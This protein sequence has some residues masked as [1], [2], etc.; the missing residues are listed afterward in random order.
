MS[1]FDELL[2]QLNAEQEEQ[3]TLAKALPAD[4]GED[5]EAIQAAADEDAEGDKNPEDEEDEGAE[6]DD[7][8][9]LVKSTILT[10]EGEEFEV[11]DAEALV[12]S[13]HDVQGRVTEVE[14][15]LAKGLETAIGMIKTQ[16]ELIKSLQGQIKKLGS[17]GVGRKTVLSVTEKPSVDTLAKSQQ[18][19]G[20][21]KEQF[22]AKSEAAWQAGAITGIEYTAV[23]VALRSGQKLDPSL[24]NRIINHK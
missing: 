3:S 14:S 19:E 24:I 17:Q 12:K 8:A 10:A 1:Q 9:P 11:V 22:L 13:L 16:G 2:A 6:E 7:D 4:D 5:D 18:E 20:L 21:T 23:D 15:V